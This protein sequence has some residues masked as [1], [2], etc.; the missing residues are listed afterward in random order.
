V[1]RQLIEVGTGY[2]YDLSALERALRD[3]T[4][5]VMAVVA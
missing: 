3:H 2:R 5:R 4:G 1:G